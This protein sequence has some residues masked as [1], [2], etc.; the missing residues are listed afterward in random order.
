LD[1]TGCE[2]ATRVPP[3]RI[4]C[5]AGYWLW[6]RVVLVAIAAVA[7]PELYV[8]WFQPKLVFNLGA[9]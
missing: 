9:R 4:A 1:G 7:R 5:R 8:A 6:L 2:H 3:R